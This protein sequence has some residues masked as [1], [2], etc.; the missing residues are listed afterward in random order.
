MSLRHFLRL[1]NKWKVWLTWSAL[2]WIA[3]ILLSLILSIYRQEVVVCNRLLVLVFF[4]FDK[5]FEWL[6]GVGLVSFDSGLRFWMFNIV[7]RHVA[8]VYLWDWCVCRWLSLR[9]SEYA[10]IGTRR[11]EE[12][13][14]AGC[15]IWIV[16]VVLG[17]LIPRLCVKELHKSKNG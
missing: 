9:C 15:R 14:L 4:E 2:L 12:S 13:A 1:M 5:Q 6:T 3:S 17:W 10:V 8:R 11:S 7:G 16:A